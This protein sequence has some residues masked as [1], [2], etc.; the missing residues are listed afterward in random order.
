M[1][2]SSQS[3]KGGKITL[4]IIDE[5]RKDIRLFKGEFGSVKDL[6]K[7][8]QVFVSSSFELNNFSLSYLDEEKD[9]ITI[10][11]EY[12]L[13]EAVSYE[14]VN[15]ENEHKIFRIFVNATGMKPKYESF[16]SSFESSSQTL[17]RETKNAEFDNKLRDDWYLPRYENEHAL[18]S[19]IIAP[20]PGEWSVEPSKAS[21]RT[22]N[23]LVNIVDGLDT[24]NLPKNVEF[25]SLSM[26]MCLCF[27]VLYNF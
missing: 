21:M 20:E 14:M 27:Y 12:D 2:T 25:I 24:S 4:K 19:K 5:Q 16:A 3:W 17:D 15:Y 26:G 13:N 22:I 6:Y 23:P 10:G 9:R 18:H 1:A 11:S 7:A 8:L